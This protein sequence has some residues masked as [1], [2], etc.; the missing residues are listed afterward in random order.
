M[1][2]GD[3]LFGLL[4]P[5]ATVGYL[6]VGIRHNDHAKYVRKNPDAV[7]IRWRTPT[8][9]DSAGHFISVSAAGRLCRDNLPGDDRRAAHPRQRRMALPG[10]YYEVEAVTNSDL[11]GLKG[12]T[13]KARK[14]TI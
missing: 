10:V 6:A 7:L 11:I 9:K 13:L 4:P 2:S 1:P 3:K 5:A 8:R 14:C 12:A